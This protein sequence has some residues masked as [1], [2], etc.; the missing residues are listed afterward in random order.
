MH[1]DN[2][3]RLKL[4]GQQHKGGMFVADNM[5]RDSTIRNEFTYEP[6]AL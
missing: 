4:I 5:V 2:I 3:L 1:H 6:L